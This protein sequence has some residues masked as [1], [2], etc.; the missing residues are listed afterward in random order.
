MSI[1]LPAKAATE[2]RAY[3][4]APALAAGDG[5]ASY[6]LTPTTVT[7]SDEE[8]EG[9]RVTFK[10][11]GGVAGSTYTIAATVVTDLGETIT[12]TLY[13]AVIAT[14][15]QIAETARDYC[16]FALRKI[17]GNGND[18]DGDELD[19]ALQQLNGLVAQWRKAGADIG[20][21]FPIVAA[22]VI[23]CPD[24][25][26]DALRYNLRVQVY[27]LYGEEPAPSDVIRARQG[28]QLV[29]HNSLPAER[30]SADYY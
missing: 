6:T 17:V 25:A 8:N 11:A 27:S 2:T 28:L 24:W 14:T 10:V 12:E 18:P 13:L 20:A 7:V 3:E 26:A 9:D 5:I 4:W 30:E 19:D 22:T 21:P 23:N 15:A 29:R 1:H 16:K